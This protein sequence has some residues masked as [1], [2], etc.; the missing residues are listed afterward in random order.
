[1]LVDMLLNAYGNEKE[2]NIFYRLEFFIMAPESVKQQCLNLYASGV[3]PK[4]IYE[5][6]YSKN[7]KGSR[8]TFERLLRKWRTDE[9]TASAEILNAGTFKG[10]TAHNATVQVDK[11]GNITQCWVKQHTESVDWDEVVKKFVD[12]VEPEKFEPVI[13]PTCSM[14][15]IPLFDL[16]FG[17]ADYETY[18]ELQGEIIQFIQSKHWDE[19]NILLGQ[20]LLHTN[21]MRG[22]TAKGTEIGVIDF[23]KAWND[24]WKFWCGII[25]Q[26]LQHS[27]RTNIRYSK[28]N[29]DECSAWCFLKALEGKFPDVCVDDSLNSRK[30]IYWQDC[31][32][33][34]GPCEYTNKSGELFK[35]FIMNYPKEYANAKVREIHTGHLHHESVDT[36][37]MV[38]RLS[39]GAPTTKWEDDNGY[40]TAHRRFQLFEWI[41]GNLKSIQYISVN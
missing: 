21:D 26:S 36:G 7:H 3:K 10:F 11:D 12:C 20:D 22:H 29:H 6:V 39:T 37:F 16:H 33:G 25:R 41:P 23:P 34:Y 17:I 1:M 13:T 38:R 8:S 5:D 28:G 15:E 40:V 31:F 19:I 2:N 35:H 9:K 24:A 32:I 27:N 4:Q 14:L 30:V 18:K